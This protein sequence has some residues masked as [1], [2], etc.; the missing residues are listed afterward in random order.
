[1][2]IK[3]WALPLFLCTVTTSALANQ[4]QYTKH[5]G[6]EYDYRPTP[7]ANQI[8][9]LQDDDRDGVINARDL[10]PDTP[11]GSEID[12]DGCGTFVKASQ[13]Q[14]LHI[15]F[16]NN[17]SSIEPAFLT[18]IRQM[19]EFL[20]TYPSTSIELQ[21]Y[22]SKV[23]SAEH[24]LALSKQRSESVRDQLLRYGVA[25]ERVNI[26]GYG[27]SVLEVE[28]TD[29]VSHARNRRV[30]AT[31]VGYKGEVVKEWTIFTTL[32]M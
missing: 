30:T 26:V 10:C 18:Q 15:L 27:D 4:G 20:Q 31:V 8:A 1:M 13:M 12:N 19:A 9:D 25:P 22:A 23:G 14:Q 21:G 16:A 6:D 32:P 3:S 7:L 17:S 28:G 24:N 2:S 5:E 11:K 29:D